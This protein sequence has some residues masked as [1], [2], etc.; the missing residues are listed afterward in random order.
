MKKLTVYLVDDHILFLEGIR[1]LLSSL[2]SVATVFEAHN[3]HELLERFAQSPA[4]LVLL[5]IEMPGMNGIQAA[6][7]LKQ[8]YPTVKIIALSMYSD[9]QYYTGMI[10]AG[11]DGFLLKNSSFSV[12]KRAIDEVMSGRNYFSHEI[13]Q[14]LVKNRQK[15]DDLSQPHPITDRETEVLRL[16]CEGLSNAEIAEKLRLSRRTVDKH[17]ENLL[18]KTN[19]KNTVALV[20]FAIRQGYYVVE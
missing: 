17:R 16:I 18:E 13:V 19:S 8:R 6:R 15:T 14:L 12:V 2:H 7:E 20:L 1:F 9:E 5:D 11:A 10:E 3:G 4:D